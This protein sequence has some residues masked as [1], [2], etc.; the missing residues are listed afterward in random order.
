MQGQPGEGHHDI[1][2]EVLSKAGIVPKDYAD[3]YAQMFKLKFVRIVEHPDGRVEVEHTS[4][5][6]AHQKRYIDALGDA[7]K[8]LVYI[9]VK[10]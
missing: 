6:S 4:K 7:G 1:A 9:S 5:L 8:T 3:H 2:K 10:R